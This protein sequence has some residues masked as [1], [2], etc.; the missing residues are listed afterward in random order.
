MN[1][2]VPDP[3]LNKYTQSSLFFLVMTTFVTS[4]PAIFGQ[5]VTNV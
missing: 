2:P 5:K 3:V 1:D 4:L